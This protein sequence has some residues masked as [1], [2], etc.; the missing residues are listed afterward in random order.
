[1]LFILLTGEI[2][3]LSDGATLLIYLLFEFLDLNV[4][5]SDLLLSFVYL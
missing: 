3:D 4:L 2:V 5:S 1:M